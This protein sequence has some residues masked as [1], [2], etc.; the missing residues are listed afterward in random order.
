[1]YWF[2]KS[3]ICKAFNTNSVF[4]LIKIDVNYKGKGD[5]F[6]NLVINIILQAS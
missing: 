6:Y 5:E 3:E 2:L 1:M 4:N